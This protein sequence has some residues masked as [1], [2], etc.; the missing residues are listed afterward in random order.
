MKYHHVNCECSDFGHMF[1]FVVDEDDFETWL[2]VQLDVQT[3]FHKRI[4]KAIKYVFGVMN[5]N[6]GR[7]DITCISKQSR[8]E[9]I[10]LFTDIN[11]K[12]AT[13]NDGNLDCFYEGCS[14]KARKLSNYCF[15]HRPLLEKCLRCNSRRINDSNYCLE[16]EHHDKRNIE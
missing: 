2:E 15:A 13:V 9:I 10:E 16:H 6:Y 4:W 12:L 8:D 7:Y 3:P 14:S 5:S 1:R 11:Q